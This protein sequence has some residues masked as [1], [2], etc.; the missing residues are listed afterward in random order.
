VVAAI[1]AQAKGEGAPPRTAAI[2]SRTAAACPL[3]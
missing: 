2:T 1:S 3:S